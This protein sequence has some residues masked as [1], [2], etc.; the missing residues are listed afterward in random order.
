MQNRVIFGVLIKSV[1]LGMSM[2]LAAPAAATDRWIGNYALSHGEE[3]TCEE[4]VKHAKNATN[5]PFVALC[6]FLQISVSQ[7]CCNPSNNNRCNSQVANGQPFGPASSQFSAATND[8]QAT[9]NGLF[10]AEQIFDLNDPN[11][12]AQG[13]E[14]TCK[15]NWTVLAGS[16]KLEA[17]SM[18]FQT[19]NCT[20]YNK[21]GVRCDG[22]VTPPGCKPIEPVVDA[23]CVPGEPLIYTNAGLLP[24]ADRHDSPFIVNANCVRKSYGFDC[25]TFSKD[26]DPTITSGPGS[27]PAP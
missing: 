7:R 26:C 15:D 2:L 4:L 10:L 24:W 21:A 27:C 9:R 11:G 20:G 14:L 19:W 25:T 22:G 1:I 5:E 13:L 12:L 8:S 3:I 17:S 23:A 18:S 6:R 16:R